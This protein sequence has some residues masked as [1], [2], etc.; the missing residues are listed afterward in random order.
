MNT[1]YA[2]EQFAAAN[3]TWRIQQATERRQVAH[4]TRERAGRTW[5][6]AVLVALIHPLGLAHRE[7]AQPP[8]Q[9][10]GR[11]SSVD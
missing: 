5:L 2:L 10:H 1:W 7:R 9:R 3:H 4:M 6:G 8:I 11:M